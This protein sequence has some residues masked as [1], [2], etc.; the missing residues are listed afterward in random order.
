MIITLK[1]SEHENYLIYI[2]ESPSKDK[3]LKHD[4]TKDVEYLKDGFFIDNQ[5]GFFGLVTCYFKDIATLL[6]NIKKE[7]HSKIIEV[8]KTKIYLR[9]FA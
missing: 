2:G 6:N 7:H 1:L 5:I 9:L 4:K 8:V 3:I